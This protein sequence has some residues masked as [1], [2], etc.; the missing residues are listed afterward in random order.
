[1]DRQNTS[2]TSSQE[3]YEESESESDRVMSSSN[4]AVQPSPLLEQRW[5]GSDQPVSS[6]SSDLANTAG[7]QEETDEDAT[8]IG[9]RTVEPHFTPQPNAFTHPPFQPAGRPQQRSANPYIDNQRPSQPSNQRYSYL[10]QG[11]PTAYNTTSPSYQ[12]DHD[13][14]LRASLSTLLSFAP[15]A[16]GRPKPAGSAETQ[17]QPVISNRVDAT[18]LRMVPESLVLG[19]SEPCAVKPPPNPAR[20]QDDI[21]TTN[22]RD[23]TGPSSTND[24]GKRKAATTMPGSGVRSSSKDR[25]VSKK[26]RRTSSVGPTS[27]DEISPTLF[28]WAVS[29]GIVVLV[30]AISFSAGYVYGKE[31]GRAEASGLADLGS[32]IRDAGRCGRDMILDHGGN[33]LK[34]LR[35]TTGAASGIRA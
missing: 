35:W 4:E 22:I 21:L 14:A 32:G 11:Q 23:N 20:D 13:A 16:R 7:Q 6:A 19:T 25:R 5:Q 29:A 15:A 9:V 30:S 26:A 2:G 34:R 18:T 24:K 28:T 3:E 31:V 27:M 8:A 1:M 10:S 33:G 17:R 12:A